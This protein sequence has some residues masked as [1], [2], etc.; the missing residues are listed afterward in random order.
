[1]CTVALAI[2]LALAGT[3]QVNAYSRE[4]FRHSSVT[5]SKLWSM[6]PVALALA[7]ALAG[8]HQVNP[9]NGE[10]CQQYLMK[11]NYEIIKVQNT[12]EGGQK[13]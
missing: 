9:D 8:T 2:A 12:V 3:P 11:Y 10:K 4:V 7:I 1:M 6:C 13:R 5:V